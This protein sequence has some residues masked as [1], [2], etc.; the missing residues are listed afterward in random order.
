M[1]SLNG[2]GVYCIVTSVE[3]GGV[4]CDIVEWTRDELVHTWGRM[5]QQ[6]ILPLVAGIFYPPFKL[7]N[8][9]C[10]KHV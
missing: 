10:M 8:S 1:S 2:G 4:H 3:R 5:Y 6:R 7:K 9:A